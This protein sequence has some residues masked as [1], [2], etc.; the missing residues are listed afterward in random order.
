MSEPRPP[1]ADDPFLAEI[2]RQPAAIRGA[3]R[4]IAG[5]TDRLRRLAADRPDGRLV[6]T[7]MGSSYD[8]CHVTVTI[9]AE[10]GTVAGLVNAA[11][12]LHFRT[13]TLDAATTLLVVSQSGQSVEIVRLLERLAGRADRPFVVSI[14]N[15]L[16]NPLAAGADVA[17]D[18]AVGDELGPSTMTFAASLVALDAVVRVL[19]G[20]PGAAGEVDRIVERVLADAEDAAAAAEALLADR[21]A[22]TATMVGWGSGRPNLVILGR[23]VSRA[24]AE[25]AALTIKEVSGAP[26]ESL[27]TADF[28]HGPL[29]LIDEELAVAFVAPRTDDRRDRPIVRGRAGHGAH[30]RGGD[31][32]RGTGRGRPQHRRR[33]GRPAARPGRGDDPV[34]APRPGAGDRPRSAARRV[35]PGHQGH[36]PRMSGIVGRGRHYLERD[37]RPIVPV[38]AHYVPV[39]GPDWPWRVG[40]EAFDR[41]FAAMAAAGLDTVRIDLLW[42]A[43]EP[44]P[45]RY[46]QDHLAVLD[47]ILEAARRHG[48]LLHPT[49]FIGG[50]V[51]DAYWDIPWRAGRR[52]HRDPELVALQAAQV[53]EL[54]R[55]WRSDPAILAWDL[56]DEPPLWLFPDTTDDDAR[57]WTTALAGSLRSVDPEHLDHDRDG[58]PGGRRRAVPGRRR[59]RPAR[60]H[61]RPSLSDLQP[62]ARPRPPAE[63][64]DDPRR[65]VRDG[66][67]GRRRTA[68]DAPRVRGL[69]GPVRSRAG[70]GLRPAAGLV[71]LRPR[72]DRLPGLVLDRRRARRLAARP[73]RP[74]APR[75]PV[76]GHRPSRRAPAAGPRPR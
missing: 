52:P 39:E 7:G 72:G 11:E 2:G 58:Q 75:D 28:R 70:R 18:T 54:G 69:V 27:V 65:G 34:P 31:R 24:T 35:Q 60:L 25:M 37:G 5:Q 15:G 20:G 23:G 73:V 49:F 16:D 44:E 74:P 29:E 67:R 43:I 8:A 32:P 66:P 47:G 21:A 13:A 6:L 40:A 55:R 26:A 45:G 50:E 10:A 30:G 19:S 22:V 56:T 51:G 76:R 17:F 48:L 14:T 1:A 33:T 36:D 12:L 59:G 64:P 68:G 62:R 53:A 4:A 71:E 38:G 61:D 9:L 46:D 57:G 3:A 42:S 63:R 41:A